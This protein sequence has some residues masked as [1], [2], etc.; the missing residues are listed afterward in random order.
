M[1][2]IWRTQYSQL[3]SYYWYHIGNHS[4]DVRA[5]ILLGVNWQSSVEKKCIIFSYGGPHSGRY[6]PTFGTKQVVP[7]R[8]L[9]LHCCEKVK[10]YKYSKSVKNV[11]ITNDINLK[12][13]KFPRMSW[14]LECFVIIRQ[15]T[16]THTLTNCIFIS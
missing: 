4:T 3:F 9:N 12:E 10:F 13:M 11:I 2:K 6:V 14:Y 15:N 7:K 8:W 5:S 16:Y 1:L